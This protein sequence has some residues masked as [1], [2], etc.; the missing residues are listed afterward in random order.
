MDAIGAGLEG[1]KGISIDRC[2]ST[3]PNVALNVQLATDYTDLHRF[4]QK[5]SVLSG[6]VG[7]KNSVRVETEVVLCKSIG[8]RREGTAV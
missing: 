4:I 8:V 5:K 3:F 2:C 1:K 7:G 6:E